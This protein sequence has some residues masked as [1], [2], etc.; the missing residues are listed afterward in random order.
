MESIMEENRCL[1][2]KFD[3]MVA[4]YDRNCYNES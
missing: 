2:V 3:Y 1:L 4:I